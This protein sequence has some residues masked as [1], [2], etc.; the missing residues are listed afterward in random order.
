MKQSRFLYKV[1]GTSMYPTLLDGDVVRLICKEYVPG[2]LVI[3]ETV[4]EKLIIKRVS[5]H[6]ILINDSGSVVDSTIVTRILG[7]VEKV[8]KSELVNYSDIDYI[9]VYAAIVVPTVSTNAASSITLTSA[10]LH[11]SVNSLG[12][13]SYASRY[14][15]W[16]LT[17]E[18]LNNFIY[19]S[20]TASIGS[21]SN[22]LSGLLANTQYVYKALAVNSAG[23]GFGGAVYFC[24][25]TSIVRPNNW[26]WS[27]SIMSGGSVYNTITSGNI[28][29]AYIM[30]AVE[31][32]NFTA[33]INEF[34]VYKG[35]S[36]Y[37][38]TLVSSDTNCTHTII[39]QAITAINA[40]GFSITSL[41]DGVNIPASVFTQMRDNLNS[42]V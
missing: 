13:D 1:C 10:T 36:N 14:F 20:D 24:T 2:D 29:I 32:N 33:R 19:V 23:I 12:G 17:L 15:Q 31:W 30:T 11:G 40:M 28:I 39:N 38:F 18:S 35:L 27:Y 22:G 3:A 4:Y 34:R 41:S 5:E 21:Y 6:N 8:P 26:S 16:G 37:S 7:K 42:I 9:L 25:L